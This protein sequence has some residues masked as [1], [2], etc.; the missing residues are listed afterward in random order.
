MDIW[1]GGMRSQQEADE[2]LAWADSKGVTDLFIHVGREDLTTYKNP[3]PEGFDPITYIIANK[4]NKKVHGWFNSIL[5]G[6]KSAQDE[7]KQYAAALNKFYPPDDWIIEEK[8]LTPYGVE[9]ILYLNLRLPAVRQ[10][11]VEKAMDIADRYS[12][13]GFHIEKLR[14]SR[15]TNQSD[16]LTNEQKE[17]L[18]T[19]IMESISNGVR[20]FRPAIQL[21]ALVDPYVEQE[22]NNSAD[23]RKWI[24]IGCIDFAVAF[25]H[26]REPLLDRFLE[27]YKDDHDLILMCYG[28]ANIHKFKGRD[29][30]IYSYAFVKKN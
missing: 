26:S 19:S 23:F 1:F 24:D 28:W 18:L 12:L 22:V 2:M 5:L 25:I 16:D 7:T 3:V 29:H 30:V 10:Y 15:Y 4:G 20:T 13:E 9:V 6:K 27:R 8:M 21:S 11:I 14:F 17:N